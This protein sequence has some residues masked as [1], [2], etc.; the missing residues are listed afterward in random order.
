MATSSARRFRAI[1]IDLEVR[2]SDYGS[3]LKRIYTD[4][5]FDMCCTGFSNIYDPSVGVQR[6]YW[7]KNIVKGVPFSNTSYYRNP[8]VDALLEAAAIEL[9]PAKRRAEFLEFQHIVMQELPDIN[10]GVPRWV[11]IYNKRAQGHS[12]TAD[13]IEGNL[14]NAYIVS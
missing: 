9:D 6:V 3:Y 7:S 11:T 2:L 12:I 14:A 1:G 13:G 5:D 8:K 4:R 10:I